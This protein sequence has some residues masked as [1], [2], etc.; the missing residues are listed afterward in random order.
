MVCKGG[1]GAYTTL[2]KG[3]DVNLE[4]KKTCVYI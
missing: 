3:G 2:E 1:G 4:E